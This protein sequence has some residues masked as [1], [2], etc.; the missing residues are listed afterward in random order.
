MAGTARHATCCGR[1]RRPGGARRGTATVEMALVVPLLL[2][3]LFSIIEFGFLIKNRAELGQAAREGA[4][5]A[6]V[7]ATPT[8]ITIGV[9]GSVS[10]I[11]VGEMT[12]EYNYR[13]WDEGSGTWGSWQTLGVSDSENNAASGDQIQITLSYDHQLLIP[14]LMGPVLG[15]D[16]NGRV[17]LAATSVMMRE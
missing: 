10:T 2:L 5:L 17:N 9:N 16:E 7:G 3:L 8:R 13:S 14:G 12:R 1:A 11:P 6:V 4:R 15:A